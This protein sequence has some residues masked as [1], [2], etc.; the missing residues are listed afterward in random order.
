VLRDG[1]AGRGDP[2]AKSF[3]EVFGVSEEE[4][5]RRGIDPLD[6]ARE[7]GVLVRPGLR[8]LAP[9]DE[10]LWTR[11]RTWGLRFYG[12]AFV[13]LGL[14]AVAYAVRHHDA[15]RIAM[16]TVAGVVGAISIAMGAYSLRCWIRYRRAG[17]SAGAPDGW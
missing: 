6:Y 16:K 5:R 4:L 7:R 15:L 2:F 14:F 13:T 10:A 9:A 17:R 8:E 12:G 1:L 11:Y 3:E